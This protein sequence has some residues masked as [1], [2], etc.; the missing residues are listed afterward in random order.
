[1]VSFPPGCWYPLRR[2]GISS[3]RGAHSRY[4]ICVGGQGSRVRNGL[5]GSNPAH[6][7]PSLDDGWD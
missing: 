6:R 2:G 1:M 7:G 3:T 4:I 5:F